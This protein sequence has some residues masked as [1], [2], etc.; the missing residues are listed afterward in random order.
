M[1]DERSINKKKELKRGMN[2][3]K[4]DKKPKTNI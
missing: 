4:H 3:Y 2:T 1:G